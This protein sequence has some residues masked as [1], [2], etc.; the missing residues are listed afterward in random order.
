MTAGS[1]GYKVAGKA[2][3]SCGRQVQ[4]KG[5]RHEVM[6]EASQRWSKEFD[7]YDEGLMIASFDSPL[8]SKAE[9][10]F[11]APQVPH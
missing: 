9:T 5:K 3:T 8:P 4:V 7:D 6:N 2:S 11:G 10:R 1:L